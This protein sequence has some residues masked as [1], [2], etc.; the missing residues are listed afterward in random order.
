MHKPVHIT[1][2]D[3]DE[4]NALMV[5]EITIATLSCGMTVA[6]DPTGI[7]YGWKETISP[8]STYKEHRVGYICDAAKALHPDT[9]GLYD[10]DR[11]G[12][13]SPRDILPASMTSEENNEQL[14]I[15]TVVLSLT[16]QLKR[17]YGGV[18]EFLALKEGEFAL[19]RIAVVEAAERGLTMVADEIR[20]AAQP[21]IVV[22][23]HPAPGGS[24][25]DEKEILW[26]KTQHANLPGERQHQLWKSRWD[27]VISIRLPSASAN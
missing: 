3:W 5:H 24:F 17:R 14:L 26:F 21:R 27:Q 13:R 10:L 15:E 20:N 4:H 22:L 7:Q 16:S 8:W 9:A 1:H 18:K 12:V 2:P 19:A 6:I 23:R 25:R 11:L